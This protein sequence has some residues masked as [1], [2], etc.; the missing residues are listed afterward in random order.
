MR[1][2]ECGKVPTTMKTNR[3]RLHINEWEPRSKLYD[4]QLEL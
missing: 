3:T 2:N 4:N 1:G